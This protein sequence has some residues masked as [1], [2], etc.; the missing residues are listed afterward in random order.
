MEGMLL[1]A[2]VCIGL[3]PR[4]RNTSKESK[5]SVD[6]HARMALGVVTDININL[7]INIVQ[8]KER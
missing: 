4:L 2:V 6:S 8:L 7:I 5:A 3:C 1:T